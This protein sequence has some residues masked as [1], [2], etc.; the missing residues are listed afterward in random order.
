MSTD[1]TPPAPA[2]TAISGTSA[3]PGPTESVS[4]GWITLFSV[5]WFGYWMANLVPLQLLLPQQLEVIDPSNKV[6][7]FAVVNAVSGLVALF[8]SRLSAQREA[9]PR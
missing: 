7:S 3:G 8:W 5:V 2:P 6:H 4:R 9:R 1:F